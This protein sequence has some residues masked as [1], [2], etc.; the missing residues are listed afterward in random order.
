MYYS[1]QVDP[2]YGSVFQKD[3]ETPAAQPPTLSLPNSSVHPSSSAF[4][5]NKENAQLDQ[6]RQSSDRLASHRNDKLG[7]EYYIVARDSKGTL[8]S[9]GSAAKPNFIVVQPRTLT[10]P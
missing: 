8:T 3:A 5:S 4:S 2:E 6:F 9:V 1:F 10:T 7:V